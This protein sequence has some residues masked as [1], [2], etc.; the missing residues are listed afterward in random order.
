VTIEMEMWPPSLELQDFTLLLSLCHSLPALVLT[1]IQDSSPIDEDS[2]GDSS[3]Y[4]PSAS[5]GVPHQGL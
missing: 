4:T 2:S 1:S 3:A 5:R